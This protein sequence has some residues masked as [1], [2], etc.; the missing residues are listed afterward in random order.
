MNVTP[1]HLPGSTDI[2]VSDE[3]TL[4]ITEYN[5][6]RLNYAVQVKKQCPKQAEITVVMVR[7]TRIASSLLIYLGMV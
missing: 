6:L 1:A 2:W 7:G 5:V 4:I 3:D